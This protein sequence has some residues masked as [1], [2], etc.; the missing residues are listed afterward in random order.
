[1]FSANVMNHSIPRRT[2]VKALCLLCSGWSVKSWAAPLIG[3]AK[4]PLHRVSETRTHMGTFVTI[5]LFHPSQ[6]KAREIIEAAF[7][8]M[9]KLIHLYNR[10]E[11]GSPL[12]YLNRQG[13]LNDPPPELLV[14]LQR[15]RELHSRSSGL[16]DVTIKPVLD[17]FEEAHIL[18]GLPESSTVRKTL[19]QVG[20]S[21]LDI[22]RKKIFFKKEG[23]G[24]TLD[25]LAKGTVVDGTID[26]L[27]KKGVEQAL[28]EAGGDLRVIGGRG[29][30]SPWR[31][32]V[33]NP[34][35][36]KEAQEPIRLS[37]GAL[38]TSGCYFVSYD[39]RQ[40][41][42]HIL[43]PETGFSPPWSTSATVI[44]PTAEAADGLATSLMLFSPAQGLS[45]INRDERLAAMIITREGQKMRSARW[46]ELEETR[47]GQLYG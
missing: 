14:I 20:L 5:A 32:A 27:R 31:I 43:S 39:S 16:F 47:P 40:D 24:I 36:E 2:F 15:A 12:S 17:L 8:H 21:N 46:P 33:Y 6:E 18:G 35:Q 10:H 22:D 7:L 45:L 41:Q 37:E 4:S 9:E 34:H 11:E 1:M 25:G 38:A 42:F 44:A 30:N 3:S 29:L 26:F 28:V 13:F 19:S 23:M